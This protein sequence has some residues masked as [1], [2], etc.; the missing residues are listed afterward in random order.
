MRRFNIHFISPLSEIVQTVER[1]VCR[2]H[3]ITTHPEQFVTELFTH[4]MIEL[5]VQIL[6]YEQEWCTVCTVWMYVCVYVWVYVMYV[7]TGM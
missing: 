3:V 1:R 6:Y 4:R 2:G 5:T 7:C